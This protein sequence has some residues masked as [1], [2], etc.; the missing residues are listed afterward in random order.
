MAVTGLFGVGSYV[1]DE[2][3][4]DWKEGISYLYPNGMA[5][6]TA[7][8]SKMQSERATDPE[9]YWWTQVLASQRVAGS[10]VT[11]VN[12]STGATGVGAASATVY[13]KPTTAAEITNFR[14]G[15]QVMI[16]TAG[17]GAFTANY[18]TDC[19]GKVTA[20]GST[21]ISIFIYATDSC[22]NLALIDSCIVVGNVNAEGAAM[23]G[24]ISYDP[25]KFYNKTQIWRTPLNIT[26]TARQTSVRTKDKY[27]R[28]KKEA[29]E[30]HSIE[31]E[32]T[33]IYGVQNEITG[34]NGQPERSTDGLLKMI[35][36]QAPGNVD[37]YKT[38]SAVSAST[39]W[40][41]GGEVW[42]DTILELVFRYGDPE[43]MGLCGNGVIMAIN[44]LLKQKAQWKFEVTTGRYGMK[45]LEWETPFGTIFLKSHPLLN[46]DPMER[47]TLIVIDPSDICYRFIQ[48]TTF[49]GMND[50][51]TTSQGRIDG[52]TEEYLTE[53]GLEVHFPQKFGLFRDFGAA[54][55]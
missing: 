35:K 25:A 48:D 16:R 39:T 33:F 38:T 5:P 31:M 18:A 46:M 4:K 37:S 55:S 14:V 12:G 40:Q 34:S 1:A 11:A 36:T 23:P 26:R 44:S 47:N 2:R 42:I 50:K 52:T 29:L 43:R 13:F 9:F 19:L 53:A 17:S 54:H 51:Q 28:M 49:Y 22:S 45:A 8:L 21:T 30:M 24:A 15:H 20:V 6:L 3:P 27:A 10:M 41:N 32:K 7:L